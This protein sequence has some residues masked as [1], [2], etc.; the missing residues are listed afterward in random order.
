MK[1]QRLAIRVCCS[2][3]PTAASF[4]WG[5]CFMRHALELILA[6]RSGEVA[7]KS[8]GSYVAAGWGSCWQVGSPCPKRALFRGKH[9]MGS[10]LSCLP[11]VG[12]D[13]R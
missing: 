9:H 2:S 4:P 10:F 6:N 11:S 12:R 13:K 8:S 3:G 5:R 7:N 1:P